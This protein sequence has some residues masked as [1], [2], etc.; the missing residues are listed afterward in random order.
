MEQNRTFS[1]TAAPCLSRTLR[2]TAASGAVRNH[3]HQSTATACLQPLSASHGTATRFLSFRTVEESLRNVF[4]K[5]GDLTEGHRRRPG[6]PPP[7]IF[8]SL[9]RW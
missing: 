6:S 4:E 3:H 7:V 8:G 1:F 2:P 9:S 5:F